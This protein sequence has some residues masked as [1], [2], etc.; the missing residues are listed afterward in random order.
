MSSPEPGG[1]RIEAEGVGF[2]YAEKA[3]LEDVSLQV[4]PG[5]VVGLLGPNGSGKSTLIKI[6]SGILPRYEGSVRVDGDEVR[7]ARRRAPAA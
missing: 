2:R 4:G 7:T 6:L 3:A 1:V 5:E